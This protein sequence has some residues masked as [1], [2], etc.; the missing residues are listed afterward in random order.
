MELEKV[1]DSY[2]KKPVRYTFKK[3]DNPENILYRIVGVYKKE[4]IALESL[5]TKNKK[6]ILTS[7]ENFKKNYEIVGFHD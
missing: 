7:F 3:K 1:I 6:Q 4:K 2:S 5:E